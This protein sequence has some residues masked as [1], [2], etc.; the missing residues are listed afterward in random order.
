M[1]YY[2]VSSMQSIKLTGES[3]KQFCYFY[4]VPSS[5][6][7]AEECGSALYDHKTKELLGKSK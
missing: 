4:L 6:T 3:K 7:L 1:S 2:E 5:K